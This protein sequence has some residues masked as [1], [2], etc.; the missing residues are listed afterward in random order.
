MIEFFINRINNKIDVIVSDIKNKNVN[1]IDVFKESIAFD[2]NRFKNDFR[3]TINI[4][5]SIIIECSYINNRSDDNV[6]D[7]KRMINVF[8]NE[9]NERLDKIIKI[10]NKEKDINKE[11][12]DI[13]LDNFDRISRTFEDYCNV[14]RFYES[15][16]YDWANYK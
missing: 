2:V 9:I 1:L 15:K 4:I 3:G 16:I 10:L 7:I 13:I 5:S 6:S 12:I 11:E 14:Y 8:N